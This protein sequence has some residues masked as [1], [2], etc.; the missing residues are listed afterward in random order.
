MTHLDRRSF[1][2]HVNFHTA[3]NLRLH[4]MVHAPMGAWPGFAAAVVA[5]GTLGPAALA[6]VVAGA[7]APVVA[8]AAAACCAAAWFCAHATVTTLLAP[9]STNTH[10]AVLCHQPGLM[11]ALFITVS[12][13]IPCL[14]QEAAPSGSLAAPSALLELCEQAQ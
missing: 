6:A 13:P 8:C 4:F 3:I 7:A 2:I 10:R 14:G 5:G 12:M 9:C 1:G 11:C